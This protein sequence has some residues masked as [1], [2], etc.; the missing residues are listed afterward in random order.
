MAG[1]PRAG[2]EDD[3]IGERPT[4]HG[5]E[6]DSSGIGGESNRMNRRQMIMLSDEMTL[7][8]SVTSLVDAAHSRGARSWSGCGVV[9][10][11]NRRIVVHALDARH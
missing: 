10:H 7:F 1:D 6:T 5:V 2:D 8:P 4:P 9:P 11:P 3:E